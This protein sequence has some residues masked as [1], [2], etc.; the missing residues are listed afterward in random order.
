V[1]CALKCGRALWNSSNTSS[2]NCPSF[3]A[4]PFLSGCPFSLSALV[5]LFDDVGLRSSCLRT[6][7]DDYKE[8]LKGATS[9]EARDR[10]DALEATAK[11][12]IGQSL[13][14]HILRAGKLAIAYFIE[15]A[16]LRVM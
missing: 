16:R 8:K 14:A 2:A 15:L 1:I 4:R 10:I 9:Q 5:I 12:T 13:V 3:A 11:L 7:L 6:Q